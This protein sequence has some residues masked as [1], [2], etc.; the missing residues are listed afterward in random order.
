MPNHVHFSSRIKSIKKEGMTQE[1]RI[2]S[3]WQGDE[4]WSPTSQGGNTTD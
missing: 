3:R 1:R 4:R 2:E